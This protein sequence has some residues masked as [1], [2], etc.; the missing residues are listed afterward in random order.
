[1][2][3]DEKDESDNDSENIDNENIDNENIDNEWINDYKQKEKV[4]EDFYKED[5]EQIKLFYLYTSSSNVIEFIKKD[6]IM[7][8]EGGILKKDKIISLIKTNQ[9]YNKIKYKLLS[10]VRFNIDIEPDEIYD[11]SYSDNDNNRFI[12]SVKYL[13]DIKYSN[14]ISIFQDLNC[15]YLIFYEEKTTTTHNTNTKKIKYINNNKNNINNKKY[16]RTRRLRLY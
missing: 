14:T 5:V 13:N 7:L 9:I 6:F 10:L 16:K 2:L 1:M 3:Q 11:F 4:Y 15:L 8:D 12:T